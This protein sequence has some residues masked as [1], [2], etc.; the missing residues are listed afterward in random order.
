MT[1]LSRGAGT[2][3]VPDIAAEPDDDA[4][5][6]MI[7]LAVTVT[8]M[9]I[10]T[11]LAT[12][13]IIGV[14]RQQRAA[15]A[16]TDAQTQASRAVQNLDGEIRYAGD[17]VVLS[18]GT[19][20]A[21]LPDPSLVWVAVDPTSATSSL[22]CVAVSLVNST[23]QRR[24]WAAYPAA[25]VVANLKAT[26]LVQGIKAVAGQP[27][28]EVTGGLDLSAGD[29]DPVEVSPAKAAELN[30]QVV[31][32]D[33]TTSRVLLQRFSALNSRQGTYGVGSQCF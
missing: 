13:G 27:P 26:T 8:I 16:F 23:L 33:L 5:V 7:E 20:R 9:S 30:L 1:G 14:L 32:G 22:R 17:M 15:V 6:T 12:V 19:A 31:A 2:P 21:D 29:G 28:F 25:G 11:V 4:G 3:L 18:G 24:E 10:V